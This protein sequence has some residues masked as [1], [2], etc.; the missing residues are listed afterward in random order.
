MTD[1]DTA[2]S[3]QQMTTSPSPLATLS[4]IERAAT[5]PE[6]D[7][8]K[9]DRLLQLHERMEAKQ[10]EQRFANA[11]CAAQAGM[12]RVSADAQNPQTRSKYASYGALDRALRPL[13]SAAGFSLS[14]DTGDSPKEGHVRIL[15]YVSCEGHT[16]THH[17]DMPSDG[18]GPQGKSVMSATHATGAASSYGMRYLLKMIFNVAVG[19]DDNDGNEPTASAPGYDFSKWSK[20]LAKAKTGDQ[21]EAVR[22]AI[23]DDKAIPPKDLPTVRQ[24][25]TKRKNELE[26]ELKS[27]ADPPPAEVGS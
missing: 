9:M 20:M 10:S 24:L 1:T 14:F 23:K 22:N 16:R 19:E 5:N 15:C 26:A 12:T 3:A 6:V 4:M 21:L 2:P 17:I 27:P 25:W 11:M 7:I 13:Y 8:E 18:K